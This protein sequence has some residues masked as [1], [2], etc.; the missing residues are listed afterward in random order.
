MTENK[1]SSILCF[2]GVLL[3]ALGLATGFGIG[4]ARAPRIGLSAHLAATQCGVALVAFGFLWPNLTFW[5]GWSVPLAHVIW[6]SF[7]LVWIGLALGALWGT[8]RVLPLAGAGHT[9]E[10][11]QERAA[12]APIAL[13]SLGSLAAI[14]LL[15]LQWRWKT[16]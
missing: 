2:A 15:L 4:A 14:I 11:W 1:I 13:G 6:V 7:Y 16:R 5:R 9:A 8:G 12:I 10:L 3:F